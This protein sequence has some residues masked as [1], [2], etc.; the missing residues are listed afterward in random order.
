M[1]IKSEKGDI[2]EKSADLVVIGVYDKDNWG[3]AFID[4]LNDLLQGRFKKQSKIH[5]FTGASGQTMLFP[6]PSNSGVEFILVVGLGNFEYVSLEGVREAAGIAVQTAKKY[7]LSSIA[8]ELFGED[9]GVENFDPKESAE[10]IATAAYLTEYQFIS[11][12]KPKGKSR[13]KTITIVAEDGRDA[14]RAT[15]GIERASAVADAVAVARDLVN[16]PAKDMHPTTLSEVAQTIATMSHG[17]I[18][19]KVLDREQCEKRGMGAYLAVSQGSDEEPKFIH[20][21]Y[22]PEK[23]TTKSVTVI[24]KG[25][26]FDSGGLSLKP[27]NYMMSMKCDMAGAAAV[28]GLFTAL[29]RTKPNVEVHGIIAATENMPSGKAMRP[30]D[31]V[32]ASNGKTIEILNT[33]AEGRLTL[34]DALVYADK[35]PTDYTIDLATLTGACVVSLG[36]E[37]AGIM[38]NTPEL[39]STL[40]KSAASAGEKIWE[41]PL[42]K[43]Y[44][45]QIES[46]VADLRNIATSQYGGTLTA[47]LFLA[48]F[49]SPE[50]KWAHIDIAGPAFAE[51]PLSSYLKKGGT[52]FGVRT[53]L[54][55]IEEL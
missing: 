40:L 5:E 6:A 10:A 37:I 31:V 48:E 18:K 47:G 17:L 14:N 34:A 46:D 11:Y 50:T 15:K 38:S 3:N 13:V 21:T 28:L 45:S 39:A 35:I 43:R 1:E 30:G 49:V 53:L 52:G 22:K 2:L 42:E 20:L 26:T 24:G 12:K 27:A 25:V 36:E 23:K 44:R 4:R 19:V 7:G 33:D 32:T 29:A 8:M 54:K 51:R 41:L 55:F 9:E 16:T